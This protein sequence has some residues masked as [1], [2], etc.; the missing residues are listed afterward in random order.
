[1][2]DTFQ[3][4]KPTSEEETKEEPEVENTE[5]SVGDMLIKIMKE[6][7]EEFQ[8]RTGRRMTYSEMREMYG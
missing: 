3:E 4:V 6:G 5:A 7:D 2:G 8:K 1:M